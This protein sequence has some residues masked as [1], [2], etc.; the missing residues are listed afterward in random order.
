M[1]AFGWEAFKES[2]VPRIKW[3]SHRPRKGETLLNQ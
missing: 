1:A 3:R 2:H